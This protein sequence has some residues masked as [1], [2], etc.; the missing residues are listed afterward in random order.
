MKTSL[1]MISNL[2]PQEGV[3]MPEP[4]KQSFFKGFFGGGSKALDRWSSP[5]LIL[6]KI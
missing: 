6:F 4:P 5:S 3:E 1:G 2:A